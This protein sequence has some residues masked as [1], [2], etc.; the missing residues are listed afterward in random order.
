MLARIGELLKK[1]FIISVEDRYQNAFIHEINTINA[2]RVKVCSV[3]FIICEIAV[4][5]LS[6]LIKREKLFSQ[7]DLY[8]LL[9]YILLTVGMVFFL[10]SFIKLGKNIQ[11]NA[12]KIQVGGVLF[13]SFILFW[14]AGISLL[15]Q[16]SYGQIVVYLSAIICIGVIPFF[17]PIV[18]LLMYGGAEGFFLILQPYFQ[19]S[20]EII[21]GNGVNSL[22]FVIFSLVISRMRYKG[23]ADDFQNKR[24]IQEK[25]ALLEEKSVLLN[26][27]NLLLIEANHRLEN[28]SQRDSLTGVYNR[29]VFDR[30]LKME[31]DRCKRH[32]IPL[33][34]MMVDID[35]FKQYNDTYG[36][37][38]GDECIKRIAE[39]L[40]SS[41]RRAS[42][43][44]TRYGGDEFALILPHMNQ[45][46]A[47]KLAEELSN[48]VIELSIP[49]ANSTVADYLTISIGA[50]TLIPSAELTIQ[51]LLRNADKALYE[52]KMIRNKI[53]I[54]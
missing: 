10:L 27:I 23:F 43:V 7:P 38:A 1:F 12:K 5:T 4:I 40:S 34:L 20:T 39:I 37:Q 21:F 3:T 54:N 9:M 47:L 29:L 8:Y 53:V 45:E 25:S 11:Q 46:S 22:T 44:I 52:A 32:H 13:A 15:D 18:L 49:H 35:F 2:A 51:D 6:L 19:Q 28:L 31:W 41:A 16:L 48:K 14:C 33:T 42:D 17:K 36:H 24:I 30:T 50:N 26:E